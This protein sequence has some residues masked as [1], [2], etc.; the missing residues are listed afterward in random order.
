M[1]PPE[2]RQRATLV[3][4]GLGVLGPLL[5][6]ALGFELLFDGDLREARTNGRG[7]GGGSVSRRRRRTAKSRE[8][9]QREK[10]GTDRRRINYVLLLLPQEPL[11]RLSPPSHL[12]LF[13]LLRRRLRRVLVVHVVVIVVALLVRRI[14]ERAVSAETFDPGQFREGRGLGPGDYVVGDPTAGGEASNGGWVHGD[15]VGLD[16]NRTREV[17]RKG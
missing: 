14:F 12:H 6:L 7:G 11:E 9:S 8:G 4:S 2:P 13:P 16:L 15:E 1:P 5:A 10:E 17:R 3:L